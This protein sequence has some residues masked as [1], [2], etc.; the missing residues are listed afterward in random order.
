MS[1]VYEYYEEQKGN[2]N[3]TMLENVMHGNKTSFKNSVWVKYC[4][5]SNIN[6]NNYFKHCKTKKHLKH[7]SDNNLKCLYSIVDSNIDI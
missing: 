5:G 1:T 3:N 7:F 4:C 6:L 2:F